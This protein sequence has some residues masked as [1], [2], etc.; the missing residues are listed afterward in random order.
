MTLED[1]VEKSL[2]VLR[3]TKSQFENPL[4]LWS[5]GKDSTLT[6]SLCRDAFFG[7]VPFPVLHIDTGWEFPTMSEFRDRLAKEWNLDLIIKKSD[8]AGVVKP[9]EKMTH[10]ECCQVLKTEVFRETIEKHGFDAAILSIRSDEKHSRN[11]D[12]PVEN[13]QNELRDA[14]KMESEKDWHPRNKYPILHWSEIDVWRYTKERNLPVNPLYFAKNG[15]RYKSIGFYPC[16]T[17]IKSEAN[18]VEKIMNETQ[19]TKTEE[20]PGAQEKEA[21]EILEKLKALGYI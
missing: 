15:K 10:Q 13:G 16:S 3:E 1:L 8:N 2:L 4:I 12:S 6:L 9:S 14:P 11:Q 7:E 19:T 18:T 17:P 5:T 20:K 21:K